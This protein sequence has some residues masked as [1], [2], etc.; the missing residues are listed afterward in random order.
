MFPYR[1]LLSGLVFSKLCW[2]VYKLLDNIGIIGLLS[3][4]TSQTFKGKKISS[5]VR[6]APLVLY[7]YTLLTSSYKPT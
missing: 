6:S 5:N 3:V 4:F 2:V 7:G 1:K